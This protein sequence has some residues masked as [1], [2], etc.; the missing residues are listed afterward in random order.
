MQREQN[1]VSGQEWVVDG[2]TWVQIGGGSIDVTERKAR[3]FSGW[4][5]TGLPRWP[6]VG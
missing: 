6:S 5:V 1:A 2:G 4:H 3:T